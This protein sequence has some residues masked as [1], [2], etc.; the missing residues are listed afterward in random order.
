MQVLRNGAAASS[1]LGLLGLPGRPHVVGGR[2]CRVLWPQ[3][4][5]ARAHSVAS[6]G[7]RVAEG[8]PNGFLGLVFR[9][10]SVRQRVLVANQGRCGPVLQPRARNRT[11]KG[12]K[13]LGNW[14]DMA[15]RRRILADPS[16]VRTNMA[17]L[18]GESAWTARAGS[19]FG[20]RDWRAGLRAGR[21]GGGGRGAADGPSCGWAELRAGPSCGRAELRA[22][23]AARGPGGD[24]PRRPGA[25]QG[26]QGSSPTAAFGVEPAASVP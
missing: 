26:R 18:G 17:A 14:V 25:R 12:P 6:E 5:P 15:W 22:G 7:S 20:K 21:A 1:G 2:L 4:V 16:S 9:A 19:P 24:G 8:A 10:F 11:R 13:W 3:G 23:R